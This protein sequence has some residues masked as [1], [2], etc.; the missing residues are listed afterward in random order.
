VDVGDLTVLAD[1]PDDQADVIVA[2]R[3]WAAANRRPTAAILDR[4]TI[5]RHVLH[6]PLTDPPPSLTRERRLVRM[7]GQRRVPDVH[8]TTPGRRDRDRA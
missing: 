8:I 7:Q 2:S 5:E 3:R 4:V 1:E 6:E